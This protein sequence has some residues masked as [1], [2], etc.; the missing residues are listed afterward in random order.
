M[1]DDK[2]T[3]EGRTPSLRDRMR[4]AEFVGMSAVLALFVG[5]IVL[6]STRE[7]LLAL[8]FFGVAFIVTLVVIALFVLGSKPDEDERQDLAEQNHEHPEL[9][10]AGA[11]RPTDGPTADGS[12]PTAP[13]N[14]HD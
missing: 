9:P 1:S 8:V 6:L 12:G 3:P 7:P 10:D 4:P 5:L 14:P 2:K 13:R 11:H